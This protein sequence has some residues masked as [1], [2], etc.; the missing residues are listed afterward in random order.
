MAIPHGGLIFVWLLDM[1]LLWIVLMRRG[2][3][4]LPKEEL[5]ETVVMQH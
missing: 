5:P 4:P 3:G 1:D 2:G